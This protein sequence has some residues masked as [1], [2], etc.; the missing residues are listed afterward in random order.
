MYVPLFIS[1]FLFYV[2]QKE[3]ELEELT[4][5]IGQLTTNDG[6]NRSIVVNRMYQEKIKC[7][8]QEI[9]KKNEILKEIKSHIRGCAEREA[10]LLRDIDELKEKVEFL[11]NFPNGVE[12][13]N[14]AL[15]ALQQSRLRV[16]TLECEKEELVNELKRLRELTNDGEE[17]IDVT[18]DEI[19]KKLKNYDKMLALE[20]DLRTRIKSMEIEKERLSKENNKLKKELDSFDPAFFD[21]LEDLKYNYQKSLTKNSLLEKQLIDLSEQLGIDVNIPP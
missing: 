11:Q 9:A 2:L 4:E 1:C 6:Q 20:V 14:D 7:L 13:E 17:K 12:N 3:R 5:R 10:Q 19:I 21:E 8:D 15:A 18:Q 16:R